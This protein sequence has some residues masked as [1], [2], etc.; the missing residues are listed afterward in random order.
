MFTSGCLVIQSKH[1]SKPDGP[2]DSVR[3]F[4]KDYDW[5]WVFE[6]NINS[7]GLKLNARVM[8]CD[9]RGG[10]FFWFYLLPEPFSAR[11]DTGKQ[12]LTFEIDIEPKGRSILFDP[13][14][15]FYVR[16]GL[17]RIP[18]GNTYKIITPQKGGRGYINV[19]Y[20]SVSN[21]VTVASKT[22][23]FLEY[24][25]SNQ[26]VLPPIVIF[27]LDIKFN[28]DTPFEISIEGISAN[29]QTI[30]IP[31]IKYRRKIIFRPEFRLPY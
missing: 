8:D 5:S 10:L 29:G 19:D 7:D 17:Y 23:F 26:T 13:S 18:P 20:E 28:P 9:N 27:D 30:S 24:N 15:I 21:S 6:R 1:L 3:L 2:S 11:E 22:E 31:P 14:K 4:K 12:T 25:A 16:D